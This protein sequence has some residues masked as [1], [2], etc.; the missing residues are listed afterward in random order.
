[1][2][3]CGKL[4]DIWCGRSSGSGANFVFEEAQTGRRSVTAYFDL[5][6]TGYY[7]DHIKALRWLKGITYPR[8]AAKL[9]AAGL[10]NQEKPVTLDQVKQWAAGNVQL[11][12]WVQDAIVR[13]EGVGDEYFSLPPI[14]PAKPSSEKKGNS[15]RLSTKKGAGPTSFAKVRLITLNDE[16]NLHDEIAQPPL[17]WIAVPDWF[18]EESLYCARIDTDGWYPYAERADA[19]VVRSSGVFRHGKMSLVT[20]KSDGKTFCVR[21]SKIRG[22]FFLHGPEMTEAEPSDGFWNDG[23]VLAR[24]PDYIEG[25]LRCNAADE[26]GIDAEDLSGSPKAP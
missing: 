14:Q 10:K 24:L 17:H 2:V 12:A 9:A 6:T 1:M 16:T 19:L 11:P 15:S 7:G 25:R 21:A 13:L 23:L 18:I 20:R 26:D 8:L 5:N 3:L 22:K 4:G